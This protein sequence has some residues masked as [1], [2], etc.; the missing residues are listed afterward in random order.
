MIKLAI[1]GNPVFHSKSTKLFQILSKKHSVELKYLPISIPDCKSI[2]DFS[3]Y[4]NLDGFN[5]TTP[6]KQ[7]IMEMLSKIDYQASNLNSVNTVL[8][9]NNS[10]IGYNTDYFGI[11]QT[12][13]DNKLILNKKKVVIL[14][15]GSAARTAAFAIRNLNAKTY[16]WD[17]N[18]DK[19]IRVAEE[20]SVLSIS[21]NKLIQQ[22]NKFDYIVSTIPPNSKILRELKFSNNQIIIDTIYHNSYFNE[23]QK[24]YNY[25]FI[26]GYN[27][28]INQAL[29]SFEMFTGIHSQKEIIS[30]EF[31]NQIQKKHKDFIFIGSITDDAKEIL[32]FLANQLNFNTIFLSE[33]INKV[34]NTKGNLNNENSS[35]IIQDLFS[36]LK[37]SKDK[38][39]VIFDNLQDNPYLI[40]IAKKYG[41]VIWLLN[42]DILSTCKNDL[43][44]NNSDFIFMLSSDMNESKERIVSEISRLI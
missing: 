37:K 28:L 27:W 19:A 32:Q 26:S 14:G 38:N 2:I 36:K 6:I 22:I 33:E 17:R 10:L 35:T 43:L 16:I 3:E 9:N 18:E 24:I 40:E 30:N 41:N 29:L 11:L 13:W 7:S 23:N 8:K 44:Y 15:A 39:L 12:I 1:A 4:L 25:T 34:N 31:Y 21:D 20:L 5:I 42:P